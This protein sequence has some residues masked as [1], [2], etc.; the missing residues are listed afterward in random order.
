MT[1]PSSSVDKGKRRAITDEEPTETSPLLGTSSEASTQLIRLEI[2]PRDSFRWEWG[3]AVR[4]FLIGFAL[5]LAILA[6][7]VLL[8]LA[9]FR[10][11]V[12]FEEA[13]RWNIDDFV[14]RNISKPGRP[15]SMWV[16]ARLSVSLSFDSQDLEAWEENAIGWGMNALEE[17][18]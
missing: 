10:R 8:A 18:E 12:N 9:K 7:V 16:E 13:I 3:R 11:D 4:T 5:A 15:L 1:S 14:V 2:S 17:V 6:F